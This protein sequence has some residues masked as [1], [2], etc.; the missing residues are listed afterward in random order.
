MCDGSA[1]TLS[2]SELLDEWEAG[3]AAAAPHGG[4]DAAAFVALARVVDNGEGP[5]GGLE[6]RLS[7]DDE[8]AT[9]HARVD[10]G[11]VAASAEAPTLALACLALGRCDEGVHVRVD[12]AGVLVCEECEGKGCD[13]CD[14]GV[15]D[16][17][18]WEHGESV[19]PATPTAPKGPNPAA[20]AELVA[21]YQ[22][23]GDEWAAVRLAT[24]AGLHVPPSAPQGP[25]PGRPHHLVWSGVEWV[26][27][28]CGCRYHPDDDNRSHGGAP[29]VHHCKEHSAAAP[30]GGPVLGVTEL[31]ECP[32]C[33]C[34][35]VDDLDTRARC[36]H[37]RHVWTPGEAPPCPE[38]PTHERTIPPITGAVEEADEDERR[39]L[40]RR[41]PRTP[42]ADRG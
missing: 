12:A 25:E 13:E 37:C 14:A 18:G 27:E 3:M 22:L 35:D 8:T 24:V 23:A 41:A 42:E 1:P 20:L 21:E 19:L 40:A 15:P 36:L 11:E 9:Y 34:D 30:H 2:Y 29:H 38:P 28:R 10:A 17:Y 5:A 16:K 31:M 33:G 26:D 32:Q 4:T 6:V 7:Y 39:A